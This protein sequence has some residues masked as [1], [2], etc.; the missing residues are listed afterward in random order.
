MHAMAHVLIQAGVDSVDNHHSVACRCSVVVQSR[1]SKG[2][3]AVSNTAL[4][5]L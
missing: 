5:T 3:E 2:C 4:A 1:R